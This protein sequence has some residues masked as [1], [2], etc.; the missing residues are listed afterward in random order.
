MKQRVDWLD[1]WVH[2][3]PSNTEPIVR[4]IAEAAD[5]SAAH[6]LVEQVRKLTA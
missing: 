3:R 4:I 1:R 5:E 2:V 6:A